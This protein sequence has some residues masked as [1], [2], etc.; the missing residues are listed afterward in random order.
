META[1]K[2]VEDDELKALMK[3]NGIGRPSTRA[4]IIETLFK[5]TYI[6]KKG[7]KL[8]PT[9][10]GIN[11]IGCI[12]NP[13]LK[14]PELT[15]LWE[16]KLRQIESGEFSAPQFIKEMEELVGSMVNEVLFNKAPI[17]EQKPLICPK[18]KKGNVVKGKTA[19]GC[20]DWKTGCNF[21]I[22]FEVLSNDEAVKL[23]V[24]NGKVTLRGKVYLL[25]EII[26]Q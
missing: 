8:L 5:R 24:N 13:T 11:L 1:G 22:P 12:Q 21:R 18:C 2:A 26:R 19:F 4:N 15:G 14:S 16:K 17:V 9:E 7:K 6:E 25:E 23:L 3:D 20:S 10:I